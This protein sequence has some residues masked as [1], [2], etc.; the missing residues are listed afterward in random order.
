[1]KTLKDFSLEKVIEFKDCSVKEHNAFE[2][3]KVVLK[4]EAIEWIVKEEN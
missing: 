4:R 2:I 1:M 3:C